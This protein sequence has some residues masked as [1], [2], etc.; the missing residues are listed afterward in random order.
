MIALFLTELQTERFCVP[1]LR[2]GVPQPLKNI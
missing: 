1:G 2:A